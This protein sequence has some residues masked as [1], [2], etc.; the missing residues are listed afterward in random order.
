MILYVSTIDAYQ[1]VMVQPRMHTYGYTNA[2]GLETETYA[3]SCWHNGKEAIT[4]L[5]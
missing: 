1:Y 5:P 4:T 2:L 3:S